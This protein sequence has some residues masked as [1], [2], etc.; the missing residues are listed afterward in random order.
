MPVVRE[1]EAFSRVAL[2]RP[3]TLLEAVQHEDIHALKRLLSQP[4]QGD[5]R[6]KDFQLTAAI[7]EAIQLE[8]F[9]A[10][11]E[12]AKYA[13][14]GQRLRLFFLDIQICYCIA[15]KANA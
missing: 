8:N 1:R 10:I 11:D 12:L 4:F 3:D 15:Q 9:E 13:S 2:N 5:A 6:E 14:I 7:D